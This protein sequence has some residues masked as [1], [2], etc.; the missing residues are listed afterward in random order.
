MNVLASLAQVLKQVP[1][2]EMQTVCWESAYPA[3]PWLPPPLSNPPQRPNS[4]TGPVMMSHLDGWAEPEPAGVHT[5][6]HQGEQRRS[7]HRQNKVLFLSIQNS[8]PNKLG[9]SSLALLMEPACWRTLLPW[10]HHHTLYVCVCG[11][12]GLDLSGPTDEF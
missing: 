2:A 9:P 4:K 11:G 5:P 8:N 6:R 1:T 7:I 12:V 3:G 10:S